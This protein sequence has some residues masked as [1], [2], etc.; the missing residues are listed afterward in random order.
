MKEG[1]IEELLFKLQEKGYSGRIVK[2][3]FAHVLQE[4]IRGRRTSGLFDEEFFGEERYREEL[5]GYSVSPLEALS[6]AK[7]IIIVAASQ[8]RVG[9]VFTY[10]GKPHSVVIPPHYAR[11]T[12][13][14]IESI[15]RGIAPRLHLKL[16]V[17]PLKL[18]AVRSGLGEYGRNNLCYVPQMGSF[19]RLVAFYLDIPCAEGSFTEPKMMEKCKLCQACTR[20]CPTR[21]ITADRFLIHAERC[22]TFHNERSTR[23]ASWIDP[24]WHN[25]LIGCLVCQKVCPENLGYLNLVENG[26]TF[27]EEETNLILKFTSTERLPSETVFKLKRLDMLAYSNVVGRNLDVLLRRRR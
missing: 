19:H 16:A 26:G 6:N 9:L 17:L 10:H 22:L 27:S 3:E 20:G 1:K 24:T 21:A 4:E 2:A 12:D 18:L 13:Y 25:C 23:F 14:K 7:S 11:D 15:I 5:S 8:P